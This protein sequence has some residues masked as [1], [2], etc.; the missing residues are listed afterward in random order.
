MEEIIISEQRR[1]DGA[2]ANEVRALVVYEHTENNMYDKKVS[3]REDWEATVL[4][5]E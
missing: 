2:N 3:R 4:G 1:P 5:K